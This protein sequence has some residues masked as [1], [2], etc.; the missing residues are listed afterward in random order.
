MEVES[1]KPLEPRVWVLVGR[2][3][4]RAL[5][6]LRA[7]IDESGNL[8][9]WLE[10]D[11]AKREEG[12]ILEKLGLS[13]RKGGPLELNSIRMLVEPSGGTYA[14]EVR[15]FNQFMTEKKEKL[16]IRALKEYREKL[17]SSGLNGSTLNKIYQAIAKAVDLTLEQTEASRSLARDIRAEMKRAWPRAHTPKRLNEEKQLSEKEIKMLRVGLD[18]K[19]ALILE[20]FL[21]TGARIS[22]V[23]S[24]RCKS[25]D[26]GD[27]VCY[28]SIKGKGNRWRTVFIKPDLFNELREVFQC[29]ELLVCKSNGEAYSREHITRMFS[30]ESQSIIGRKISPHNFRHYVARRLINEISL[31]KL[32]EYLG[33]ADVKTTV[34]YYSDR[35]AKPEEI[36]RNL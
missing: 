3:E 5:K 12:D 8:A 18:R 21:S 35:L 22:E 27:K 10:A 14:A 7:R 23:L 1:F 25:I 36:F 11:V 30:K 4:H 32:A 29:P 28:V 9:P 13:R 24:V 16:S 20:V 31:A 33:H 2:T 34:D 19:K 26:C 6:D 17:T 15:R